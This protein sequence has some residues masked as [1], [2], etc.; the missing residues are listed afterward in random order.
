MDE[1]LKELQKELTLKG[2][3]PKS[4]ARSNQKSIW[5]INIWRGD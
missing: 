5:K 4:S 2:F 1:K 3:R